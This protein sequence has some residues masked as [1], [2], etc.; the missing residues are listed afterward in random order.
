MP[1][2]THRPD[3]KKEG[4]KSTGKDTTTPAMRQYHDIKQKAP[5]AILFFRMGDF[6]E[7]FYDDALTAA[8]A[9]ELTLTSRQKDRGGSAIPMCGIPYHAADTY[10]ARLIRKGFKVAVCDQLEDAKQAKGIVRRDIV[11]VVTPS[12]YLHDGYLEATEPSYLMSVVR[13]KDAVG[14]ALADLS[15]G[16]FAALELSGSESMQELEQLVSTYRPREIL[17]PEATPLWETSPTV[18]SK[19]PGPTIDGGGAGVGS[20]GPLVTERESWHFDYERSRSRLLTQFGTV[21]LEGFGLEGRVLAVSA[22]GAALEYL[23]ETQRGEIAHI[24]SIRFLEEA[25]HLI[26]DPVT[27]RNLELTRSLSEGGRQGS[28]LAILD[29]TGTSMGARLLKSWLLRPLVDAGRIASRLDAV[30]ELAFDTVYR[31]K[32]REAMK[33]IQDLERLLSRV[34]LGSASPRDFAAI[35]SSLTRV[36][37]LRGLLTGARAELLETLFEEMDPLEDVRDDIERS[38]VSEPPAT[39]KEGGVIRASVS[40]ELDELRKL[41]THGKETL[42]GIELRERER[43]GISN[44][45]VRFNKVFGY[46]I[47]VTK[48]K[49]DAVPADYVRKQTLVGSERFITQELKEYEDKILNAEERI[50]AL[51]NELFDALRDRVRAEAGRLRSTAEALA[52]LDVLASLAEVATTSNYTK[53]LLHEGYELEL[54]EARHPVIEALSHEPFVPNDVRLDE[55]RQLM[56]LTGPNMGGKSTFLRQTALSVLLAQMGSFVPAKSAKLPI[57]DRIFTRVGA[58]DNLF[59]GRS[60]F[61]VEMQETAHILHHATA[62]SLVLLDEIGRGTAT[63][64]GLSIA[65]SVAEHLASNARL[66]SKT[67]FATH[68]HELTDLACEVAGVVNCHVSARE[69]HDDI[70][71]LRKVIDGGSDRSYGI[72]VARL[73]GLPPEVIRRARE[74]L[75][76]LEKSEFD[77]EG[78]PRI[79][80]PTDSSGESH[81]ERQL[82]LFA[83]A[84][85]RVIAEIRRLDPD[86]VSPLEALSL[87]AELK[88]SLE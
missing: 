31:G 26:L 11:R 88:K 68:Y 5:D 35:A 45:R 43:T 59:R 48:S 25:D 21:S 65:W 83:N 50:L 4:R 29:R 36:P 79:T 49:L 27:Q 1:T 53:P 47:E 40:H 60:T 84:E 9:L 86:T 37:L 3:D 19:T 54:E 15:T 66:R 52:K 78:H 51:E 67:I 8:R 12:T 7:M 16:D 41:R 85:A 42:V 76:Q 6:Y 69:W 46:Y 30:E 44:L 82:S 71:F 80:G 72:Q 24:V 17:K 75:I 58:S 2:K 23:E 55:D 62:R 64:D 73:A 63:F 20:E 22:A 13:A 18:T 28:L 32:T 14:A 70:V 77:I 57:I 61:M 34:T 56:I 39:L 74:I 81:K 38:L 87:L 33:S 10:I